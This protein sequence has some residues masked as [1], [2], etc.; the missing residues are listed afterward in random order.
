[1]EGLAR[2][3]KWFS[4]AAVNIGNFAPPLDTGIMS[5]I[6]PTIAINLNAPIQLVLWVPLESLIITAAFMP[7]FGRFSDAHGRKRFFILGLILFSIGAYL[8]GNSFTIYELLIYRVIQA[9]G[10]AFILSNGRALIVDAFEPQRRGF[11][12]GTHIST[13]YVATTVGVAITGSLVNITQAIG[14][15]YVFYASASVAALA[16]PIS[17]IA[18]HESPKNTKIKTD[19]LGAITFAGMLGSALVALT[20]Y[21]NGSSAI[22]MYIQDIYIP[23]FHFYIYLN[24]AV[25]IPDSWIAIVGLVSGVLFVVRETTASQPLINF[26]TFRTNSMFASTNFSALFIYMASYST[27]ILLS[28]YLEIVRFVSPFTAGTILTVEPLFVTIFALFGGWIASRTVSREPAVAGLIIASVSLLLLSTLTQTTPTLTIAIL[29]GMLGAGIGIFAPTN[30]NANLASVPPGDRALANGILGM[31]RHTGQA[32]SLAMGTILIGFFLYGHNLGAIGQGGT[33]HPGQ[34]LDA[35][36]ITFIVGAVLAG[37]GAV[38]AYR[39]REPAKEV[40]QV[41]QVPIAS[42]EI[43]RENP[44]AELSSIGQAGASPTP[45]T[46]DQPDGPREEAQSGTP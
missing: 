13:I 44:S 24:R 16:I 5:L 37:I 46:G 18:L 8:S 41:A 7:I 10:G 39:G 45:Q 2:R 14:W 9:L 33:V 11:A 29:L 22:N 1:L 43:R 6:L 36:S 25:S 32:I 40:A 12:L 28:F 34:Y 30:T 19:W 35:L 26:H 31:M 17:L 3:R 27:L 20:A 38:F 21:S 23:V 42:P 4:L 15:R